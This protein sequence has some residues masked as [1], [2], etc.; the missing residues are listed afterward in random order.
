[1]KLFFFSF[2]LTN[3]DSS[4]I[5][6]QV[7][8]VIPN[9]TL[10]MTMMALGLVGNMITISTIEPYFAIA[11]VALMFGFYLLQRYYAPSAIQLQRLESN[12]RSPYVQH[13]SETIKGISIIRAFSRTATFQMKQFSMFNRNTEALFGV[14]MV[15]RWGALRVGMLQT[16]LLLAAGLLVASSRGSMD[17]GLAGVVMT[18]VMS[19]GATIGFLV[20][21]LIE[22]SSA[23]NSVER[24]RHY[25][26][27]IPTEP[28]LDYGTD[29]YVPPAEWPRSGEVEY[30]NVVMRYRPELP[31]VVNNLSFKLPAGAK[32][33]VVGRTGSGKVCSTFFFFD[34]LIF[35]FLKFQY[36]AFLLSPQSSLMMLLQRMYPIQSGQ[37][38]VDGIDVSK[39]G[40]HRLRNAI[41]IVPQDAVLLSGSVRSNLDPFNQ[42]SDDEI[43]HAL[44]AVDL[45]ETI[46]A[47][48]GGL[49]SPV[50]EHGSNF[51]VGQRQ[52]LS[53]ARVL[54]KQPKLLLLDE[55]TSS[56]DSATD[57]L[58]QNTIDTQFKDTTKLIIAHRLNTV[59]SADYIMVLDKGTLVEFG[60]PKLLIEHYSHPDAR[61]QQ[62]S[63]DADV[64]AEEETGAEKTGERV[65][66]QHKGASGTPWMSCGIFA[67][68]YRVYLQ[69][70]Q[71]QQ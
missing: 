63:N 2:F 36:H 9:L 20:M 51:S 26:Y 16:L 37:I 4:L 54:L 25:I 31:V 19:G 39:I 60:P 66:V 56:I 68:M 24:L 13:F 14:R 33:G 35:F 18:F 46:A 70:S 32:I 71:Q 47:L 65:T 40:L 55:A 43:F 45:K 42:Y 34:F 69:N 1:M 7:D 29:G 62:A 48:D 15:Y 10:Y 12:T 21:I 49:K 59:I 6:P 28:D 58:I 5:S 8:T 41:G 61:A 30:K 50:T 17:V 67:D 53:M 44:E 38:L 27:A 11:M 64:E 22:L 57:S 52:L 23:F 3:P